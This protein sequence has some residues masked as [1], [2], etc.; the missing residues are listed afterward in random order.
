[1][2]HKIILKFIGIG[3]ISAGSRAQQ[4]IACKQKD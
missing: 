3:F 4:R 2:I 1:M